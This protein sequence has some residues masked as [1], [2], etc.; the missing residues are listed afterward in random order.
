M[1]SPP[2]ILRSDVR[3]HRRWV[4]HIALISLVV[5]IIAFG[6]ISITSTYRIFAHTVDEPAHLAAGIELLDRGT[7]RY[8]Q[9]H[10]PLARLAVAIGPYLLGARSHGKADIFDEGLAVLYQS[11]DYA[12]VLSAARFG[13]LPFFVT[14]VAIACVWALPR[15]RCR[16]RRCD[17]RDP[18]DHTTGAHACW[19][20]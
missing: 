12:A 5:A 16:R 19:I 13:V 2:Q 7:Y 20:G 11:S 4:C 18:R 15:F 14:L 1:C 9:Q 6:A 3:V 10:P 8:E 17:G